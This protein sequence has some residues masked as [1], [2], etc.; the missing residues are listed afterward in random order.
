MTP[1]PRPLPSGT[2]TFLFTDV[3]DAATGEPARAPLLAHAAVVASLNFSPDG[4]TF[5]TSGV[6]GLTYLWDTDTGRALG[7]PFDGRDAV[8][9]AFSI[10]GRPCT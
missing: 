5:A 9:N 1:V 6:D 2:V 3:L 8:V 10:D 4:T 7:T